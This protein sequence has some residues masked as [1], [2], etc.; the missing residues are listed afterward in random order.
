MSEFVLI[1]DALVLNNKGEILFQK[2]KIKDKPDM[3]A[4]PGGKVKIGERL[5]DTVVREVLEEHDINIK[6]FRYLQ[7]LE[8]IRPKNHYIYFT[9]L[10][11]L[12]SGTP[13]IMEPNKCSEVGFFSLDELPEP[14]TF[15]TKDYVKNYLNSKF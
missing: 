7:H 13:K 10:A 1:C 14:M 12:I 2:R 9:Y 5:E 4:T 6:P 3:W 11:K 15:Q 8:V